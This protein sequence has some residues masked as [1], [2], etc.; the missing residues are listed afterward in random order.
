MKFAAS[1]FVFIFCSAAFGGELLT[2][3]GFENNM[4]GWVTST[5][6]GSAASSTTAHSGSKSTKFE[7]ADYSSPYAAYIYAS[8]SVA[9][10][11]STEYTLSIWAKDNWSNGGQPMANAVTLRLEYYNAS[12]TLLRA[13]QQ[14][15]SLP[16]D[17]QWHQ[18]TFI[19]TQ[20]PAGTTVVKAVFGTTQ[21]S[22]W[23]KS[24]L[25]DDVSLTGVL[26]IVQQPHTGDLNNDLFVNFS[27]FS[28]LASGW[29]QT[30]DEIDLYDMADNWLVNYSK[31][32]T[33]VPTVQSVSQY[34][35]VFFDINSVS[36]FN[37]PYNPDEIKVDIIFH[38]PDNKQIILPCFYVSGDS[39][40]SKWQGRF[41]PVQIGQYSYQ[42]KV[43][44]NG[45]YDGFS[46][47]SNL[48]V[49]PSNDDGF[50]HK[51]PD[52]YYFWKYD[53]GKAFRGVGE[54]VAWDTRSYNSQMYPY[55]YMLPTLGNQG[56]NFVRVWL[57]EW[58]IPI[59]WSNLGRY[60]AS[61]AARLDQVLA[62]AEQN[63]IYLL[64][65]LNTYTEFKSVKNTWGTGDDWVRNPYNSINGGPC[66]T[67]ASFFTNAAAKNL[68]KKKLRYF[69]ARWGYHT[70]LGVIEF[71]N[72]VDH[73]YSDGDASV[74]EADIVSWH[75]EMSTYLKSIDPY[76]HLVTTSFSYKWMPDLWNV[77]NLDFTQTHPYG[78]TD[79]AYNT[80]TSY[81]NNFNKPYV[82][83][84]FG[85]SWESAGTSSNH[86][87]FRRELHMGMWRG[88]FSPTPV[89]PMVW[90]WENLAYYN[91]WDVFA[92]TANFS[93]Q[94][95]ADS[96]GFLTSLSLNAG[97]S[98]ET[99]GIQSRG[100][101]YAW[102]RN[103]T[104]S[105]VSSILTI[106][107]VQNGTYELTSYNTWLGTYSSPSTVSV[108]NSV[109]SIP[110]PSVTAD[111]DIAFRIVR[112]GI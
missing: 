15:S 6:N 74:P 32:V 40:A 105:T 108:T 70:N 13:D 84:E 62:L 19:S 14:L 26:P 33:I 107:G 78:T 16:K 24:V 96:D 92:A 69:I 58:N 55:E 9:Y 77:S 110:I 41:T 95:T 1:L 50:I 76:K 72:E 23:Q 65:T 42:V 83:E 97:T 57:C 91:D 53:S 29:Q 68:Y 75:D 80:I 99:M 93:N 81:I 112:T 56:C 10:D 88:M 73:L 37:N 3:V 21:D 52:S 71:F 46:P 109:L 35:P 2:N 102:L 7:T 12:S 90:W 94:I 18:F 54:N 63:G 36:A 51:N 47:V 49:S 45:S 59:E 39:A 100:K 22:L 86:S 60:T 106:S 43:Y 34:S 5:S 38:T 98:F 11:N 101:M 27:D 85:Y 28:Q 48:N 66:T 61:A 104:S 4:T 30:T 17:Y 111:G 89:L 25:F 20:I 31:P 67:A 44:I 8:Q 87:L 64:L 82:M 79:S 103:K